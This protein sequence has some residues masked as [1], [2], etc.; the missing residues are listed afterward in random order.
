MLELSETPCISK[1]NKKKSYENVRRVSDDT[2]DLFKQVLR[3][4]KI[5]QKPRSFFV[6][7]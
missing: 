5:A 4:I 6:S 3:G 2:D 7:D 1:E